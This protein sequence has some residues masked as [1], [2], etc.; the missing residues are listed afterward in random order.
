MAVYQRLLAELDSNGQ[1]ISEQISEIDLTDT[2]DAQVLM[3]EQGGDI[4][5]HFGEDRFLERYQRYKSHIA[6]WRQQYPKLSGVDLRYDQKVVLQMASG[7]DVAQAAASEQASTGASDSKPSNG[8]VADNGQTAGDS[9]GN[10]PSVAKVSSG[11]SQFA[12]KT[13][14]GKP[15]EKSGATVST[16]RKSA[17]PRRKQKP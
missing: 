6:E 4:L 13:K 12:A 16:K 8:P 5:V 1:R 3:P 9:D 17:V 2:E 10:Q 15:G 7:T 11:Q 14:L